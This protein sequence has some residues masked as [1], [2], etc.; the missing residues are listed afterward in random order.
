MSQ[1]KVVELRPTGGL[2]DVANGLRSL[3]DSIEAGNYG[4]VNA[5]AWVLDAD[6]REIEFGIL[7]CMPSP[8]ALFVTLVELGKLSLLQ[9][10]GK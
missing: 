7:G 5:L 6:F 2:S 4:E 8:D 1:L 10:M 9:R 3:A